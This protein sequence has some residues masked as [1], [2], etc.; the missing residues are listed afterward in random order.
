MNRVEPSV[1][2]PSISD[3]P[4]DDVIEQELAP[5]NPAARR[6]KGWLWFG[7]LMCFCF[8]IGGAYTVYSLYTD[9]QVT[10]TATQ[11]TT[12]ADISKRLS[13]H[14]GKWRLPDLT[15]NQDYASSYAEQ[16]DQELSVTQR[17]QSEML[18]TVAN[19]ADSFKALQETLRTEREAAQANQEDLLARLEA[20][21][22]ARQELEEKVA[23][24]QGELAKTG[25]GG[26]VDADGLPADLTARKSPAVRGYAQP[27]PATTVGS[28]VAGKPK[29][30][31]L[32]FNLS[33][34]RKG[35][36][37]IGEDYLP[38][39]SYAPGRI[40]IGARTSASVDAQKD[41]RPLL[42]RIEGRAVAGMDKHGKKHFVDTT[43]CVVEAAAY[44]D[45]SAEMSPAR[46]S[47]MSCTY[48]DGRNVSV[49]VNGYLASRGQYGIKGEVVRREGD[50]MTH[51]FWAGALGS[52][53]DVVQG[54]Q[55]ET[56]KSA[57]GTVKTYD[58]GD[59][60]LDLAGGA[61]K[62]TGTQMQRYYIK[63][64]EQIQPVLPIKAGTPVEI[65]FFTPV[66]LS[67][68]QELQDGARQTATAQQ[69]T[70][71]GVYINNQA[72]NAAPSPQ[73]YQ[74]AAQQVIQYA[75]PVTTQVQGSQAQDATVTNW[76]TSLY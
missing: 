20:D 40:I 73:N 55:G 49:R 37:P 11:G 25:N 30:E 34:R 21:S 8:L 16:L 46:I 56:S 76:N 14:Q 26:A 6:R 7:V 4:A 18:G 52:T 42:V 64:L 66:D 3:V 19:L 61:L 54:L 28:P 57:M 5:E 69:Q 31:T 53:G 13:Q 68:Q 47:L 36:K 60:V 70:P 41:P 1:T 50:L 33:S 9:D 27:N 67:G 43:G 45:E 15:K 59:A 2:D 62:S 35:G 24:L 75:Q 10:A 48:P 23:A 29:W 72:I 39:G 74:Q 51:A 22:V 63:R 58:G 38:P 12:A 65:V 71:S 17:K 44:G 32:E